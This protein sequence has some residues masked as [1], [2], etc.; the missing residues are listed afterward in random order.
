MNIHEYQAKELL[1]KFG[2]PVPAGFA[3]LSVE[4]AVE[5]PAEVPMWQQPE[6]IAL[7]KELGRNALI[8]GLA[9]FL[10]AGVLRPLLRQ[11]ATA[12]PIPLV[13]GTD[14]QLLETTATA[15]SYADNLQSARQIARQDPKMVANVVKGWVGSDG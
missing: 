5:P 1:A 11:L 9:L 8:G 15:N 10:F 14:Q 13:T 6:A 12:R 2:V 3:A 7:A 4:D